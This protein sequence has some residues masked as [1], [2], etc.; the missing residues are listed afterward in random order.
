MNTYS[1]VED[2]LE[3]L[4]GYDINSSSSLLWPSNKQ[5]RLARY[6]IAI[7]DSMSSHTAFG[8]ALTDRQAELCVKIILKYRRQFAKINIDVTPVEDPVFRHA[9]RT[10]DRSRRI[11]LDDQKIGIRF[12]YDRSLIDSVQA[13][14]KES[15]GSTEW[16]NDEK[17]WWFGLTEANINWAVTWGEAYNFEI[18]PLIRS[19]FN[20]I[21]ECEQTPYDIKLVRTPTGFEI[22]NA[23]PS[24][25]EYIETKLGGFGLENGIKLIDY[26]GVLGYTYDENLIRPALLD[27]FKDQRNAHVVPDP[28]DTNLD[29]IFQY[30][31]LTNRYPI[32]IY[33]P[34][35]KGVDLSQFNENDIVR[36]NPSGKTK[37]SEY[38]IYDVKVVYANKIPVTWNYDIPLLVTTQ[39]LL[40]GGKRMEWLNRAE[41]VIYYCNTIIRE[42][43]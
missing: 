15:Q 38:N 37:T 34:G 19:L 17:V 35:L 4:G 2:Y 16:D 24:L 10:L 3:I 18:D 9:P 36:F 42:N 7:V 5:I 20:K 25:I 27:V 29:L 11:W 26:S 12:P 41:K 21:L 8:G 31:E 28:E 23:A 40:Y 30:A 13:Y 14:K 39:E 1:H 6:D 32:C 22:T 43:D 33:D